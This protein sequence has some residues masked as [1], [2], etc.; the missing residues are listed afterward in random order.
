[1][2]VFILYPHSLGLS[3]GKFQF[4]PAQ[5]VG[6]TIQGEYISTTTDTVVVT[7]YD[8]HIVTIPFS[9]LSDADVASV[10]ESDNGKQQTDASEKASTFP[11]LCKA[12]DTDENDRKLE[13][14]IDIRY[15]V[16]STS[17]EEASDDIIGGEGRQSACTDPRATFTSYASAL[18]KA[19]PAI[20]SKFLR[21]AVNGAAPQVDAFSLPQFPPLG[22]RLTA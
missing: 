11:K 15:P 20:A 17:V 19:V 3:L 21:G 7:C 22:C 6:R 12:S 10:R 4:I 13:L 5:D 14:D 2:P 1:M 18:W 8:G 9:T 16:V